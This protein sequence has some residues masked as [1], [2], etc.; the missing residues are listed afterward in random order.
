MSNKLLLNAT[1][2]DIINEINKLKNSGIGGSAENAVLYTPQELTEE[3]KKQV[4]INLGLANLPLQIGDPIT[5]ILYLD[6][7]L[8][9][10][11]MLASLTYDLQGQPMA[12]LYGA[13]IIGTINNNPVDIETPTILAIRND[14]G[15]GTYCYGIVDY[16]VANQG[17][18]A[19]GI[20]Y[21]SHNTPSELLTQIGATKT[22]WQIDEYDAMG[23]LAL[24]GI[25]VTSCITTA[26]P[27]IGFA[28]SKPLN[29]VKDSNLKIVTL[30]RPDE[31]TWVNIELEVFQEIEKCDIVILLDNSTGLFTPSQ[32]FYK[33]DSLEINSEGAFLKQ[34]KF[35]SGKNSLDGLSIP[36]GSPLE[37]DVFGLEY[38]VVTKTNINSN[39]E[40]ADAINYTIYLHP[41]EL[42]P[43]IDSSLNSTSTNAVQNRAIYN[44]FSNYGSLNSSNNW[45][46]NNTF[47][48]IPYATNGYG[49]HNG[50][51]EFNNTFYKH[52]KIEIAGDNPRTLT[53]PEKSGILATLDDIQSGSGEI[54][55]SNYGTL[56]GNNTWTGT[57]S[58]YN[59]T[60]LDFK[61]SQGNMT[62]NLK[63]AIS[64]VAG[65]YDIRFPAKSGT[66]ATTDDI[67]NIDFSSYGNL[68]YSNTWKGANN[69]DSNV[70]F[71]STT[72]PLSHYGFNATNGN[73]T[74]QSTKY[75]YGKI[76]NG[77]YTLTFP[78]KT[79]TLATVEDI[80]IINLEDYVKTTD[81]SDYA[82]TTDLNKYVLTSTLSAYGTLAGNN[83]WKGNNT[84]SGTNIFGFSNRFGS[85]SITGTEHIV[86]G[87]KYNQSDIE[88]GKHILQSNAPTTNDDMTLI[89]P[90]K[91]GTLAT[92]EDISTSGGSGGGSGIIIDDIFS[93]TSTNPLQNKVITN[94]LTNL[95]Q[96]TYYIIDTEE[97]MNAFVKD[98]NINKIVMYVGKSTNKYKKGSIYKIEE[99]TSEL[100]SFILGTSTLHI[101]N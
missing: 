81:L 25:T 2:A 51:D 83:T 30:E 96:Q 48:S 1:N 73:N 28:Y 63:G 7:S 39:G 60:T 4:L 33:Y 29:G 97:E 86:L 40:L 99:S 92:L 58:F 11:E 79:G 45:L 90:N 80:P 21:I 84:F 22:G 5:G 16:I 98:E 100:G 12:Q 46:G 69:F 20:V 10:D 91:S 54:D 14:L 70:E 44:Y 26:V 89:L 52:G 94:A 17:N 47:K 82:K 101:N 8:D 57:N 61:L 9:L 32:F 23:R 49:V 6:T 65:T 27:E 72:A 59:L 13:R 66:L 38:F 62:Y 64:G 75:E 95:Q 36:L 55:L 37:D 74:S 15:D 53:L 71:R 76:T 50:T 67:N 68:N 19:G 18:F 77:S 42:K 41:F 88:L 87:V 35:F 43:E 31:K 34:F 56:Q 93:P 85:L 3:Q 24:M 78:D